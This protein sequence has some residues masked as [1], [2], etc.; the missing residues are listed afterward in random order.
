M[1][2]QIQLMTGEIISFKG[3][4]KKAAEKVRAMYEATGV[5][6]KM[7]G[8]RAGKI[9]SNAVNGVRLSG[10]AIASQFFNEEKNAKNMAEAEAKKQ[11][12]IGYARSMAQER[13]RFEDSG[14]DKSVLKQVDKT[15][16]KAVKAVDKADRKKQKLQ[17]IRNFWNTLG[18]NDAVA[19]HNN[20]EGINIPKM[21]ADKVE[22]KSESNVVSS[23]DFDALMRLQNENIGGKKAEP[24]VEVPV[25]V[26]PVATEANKE[27]AKDSKAKS[28]WEKLEEIEKLEAKLVAMSGQVK[29]MEGIL[30][31]ATNTAK[32]AEGAVQQYNTKFGELKGIEA[33][34]S[35]REQAISENEAKIAKQAEE[36]G[37]REEQVSQREGISNELKD[38]LSKKLNAVDEKSRAVDGKEAEVSRRESTLVSRE[39]AFNTILEQF[40][41]R[42]NVSPTTVEEEINKLMNGQQVSQNQINPEGMQR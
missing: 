24:V 7:V 20:P 29:E 9:A 4:S 35:Q 26:A 31:V 15:I 21:E 1:D 25:Q 14:V 6:V 27:E 16:D 32:Q 12:N 3:I 40:A 41:V 39:Q 17:N 5:K 23:A 42:L 13:R 37:K 28:I 19:R 11:A 22:E 10:Y 34:L 30:E 2:L 36:I 33:G 38:S 18:F 8:S